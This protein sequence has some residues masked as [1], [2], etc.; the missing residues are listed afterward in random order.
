MRLIGQWLKIAV[1]LGVVVALIDGLKVAEA[2]CNAPPAGPEYDLA[3]TAL[4]DATMV[5]VGSSVNFSYT[6]TT[7]DGL[8]LPPQSVIWSP[9]GAVHQFTSPGIYTNWV[10]VANPLDDY[11]GPCA[12]SNY[13]VV[14]VLKVEI[15]KCASGFLPLGGTNDNTTTIRA[16]VTPNTAKGKFKFTLF[17]VSDEKGYCLNAPT[18]LP[19][20]GEDSDAWKDYQFPTQT[21]FTISGADSNIAETVTNDLHE[22]TVTIKSFDYGSFGKIKAEFTTQDGSLTCVAKEVGGTNEYTRLPA[23][24]NFND[25]ADSWSGDTGPSGNCDATYDDDNNPTNGYTTGDGLSRYEEYRGFSVNG[26]HTRTVPW[27][28]D[29][30]IC[31]VSSAFTSSRADVSQLGCDIHW[32]SVDEWDGAS[33]DASPTYQH[34]NFNCDSHRARTYLQR[35]LRLLDGGT[36]GTMTWGQSFRVLPRCPNNTMKA[37]VYT[38]NISTYW[39][40]TPPASEV[41]T[42]TVAHE[43]A[44]GCGLTDDYSNPGG[45]MSEY[46]PAGSSNVWHVFRSGTGAGTLDELRIRYP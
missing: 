18:N 7:S 14:T 26:T 33:S 36:N 20:S 17:E 44:H 4:A 27:N 23:D 16:F 45:I 43:L 31:D 2:A 12:V 1:V 34:I 42:R 19:A 32:I 25:I 15:E 41:V 30:F 35:A 37:V 28:K 10:T 46:L 24:T 6:A 22:A 29:V 3:V 8:H 13:V 40:N 39:T 38:G 5:L 21:V 11:S 9:Y